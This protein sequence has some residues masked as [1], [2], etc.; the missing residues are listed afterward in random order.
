MSYEK[1]VQ[2]RICE[3]LGMKST[4][5]TLSPEMNARLA[6]GHNTSMEPVSYWD[7]PTLAGAGALRSDANDMLN[8]LAANLG[9]TKSS[10]APAMDAMHKETK[11][12]GVP[13]LSIALGWHVFSR[14]GNEVIWHNGGTG[15]FRSFMGYSAKN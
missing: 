13:G 14:D 3:P 11:P 8:F 7:L 9:Y 2:S 15:G 12:T 4:G 1:L 6:T 10:L 5:I